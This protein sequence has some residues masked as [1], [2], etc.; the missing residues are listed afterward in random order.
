MADAPLPHPLGASADDAPL[1]AHSK[2]IYPQAVKGSYR[3]IKWV[4]LAVTLGI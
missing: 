4:V 3:T 2:Q 1:Y